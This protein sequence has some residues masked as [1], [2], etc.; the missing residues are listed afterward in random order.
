VRSARKGIRAELSFESID[1]LLEF[2]RQVS[3]G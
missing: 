2:A 1:G 3:R